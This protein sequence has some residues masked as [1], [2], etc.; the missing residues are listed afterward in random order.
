MPHLRRYTL[1]E[2]I[3]RSDHT[4][5]Y[6]GYRND[7]RAKVLAKCLA[8]E[9]AGPRERA[10]LRHE[11]AILKG[12]EVEGIVRAL[13]LTEQDHVLA[14]VV[15][16]PGGRPLRA[17]I[18][19]ELMPLADA[20]RVAAQIARALEGL[21]LRHVIHK[22]VRPE[23]IFDDPEAGRACLGGFG[24]ATRLQQEMP[25][26]ASPDALEGTLAY[27]SP[28]QTGRMNRA[29]DQ[30]TDLYS[31]GA[32]L[33][34]MLTGAPPFAADDSLELV[35]SH[36]AKAP[37][38]PHEISPSVPR[39][40]SDVVIKLLSKNAEDRYQRAAGVAAD[41]ELC[42]EAIAAGRTIAPFALDRYSHGGS[43]RM[44]QRLYG[45]DDELA[46]LLSAWQRASRGKAELVLVTGYSGIGKSV[47]V[48]EIH[49]E[50]AKTG[51]YFIAGKF[52]QL[53]RAVPYAS[54][55]EA[56][57]E[58]VHQLL[59]ERDA[60]LDRWRSRI[61]AA[62]GA[63]GKVLTDLI[64]DLALIIGPQPEL[65]EL[66]APAAQNR[67]ALVFQDFVRVFAS[68][69]H[70]LVI[71][72][73]DLQWADPASLALL[74]LLVAAPE[75]GSLL[76]IGAYRSNEVDAA[77]PLSRAVGEIAEAARVSEI[78]LPPLER[79]DVTR[80][81]ADALGAEPDGVESLAGVVYEKT[82]G[83]PFFLIQFLAALR[84]DDLLAFDPGAGTFRW[85]AAAIRAR[86]ITDNVVDFMVERIRRLAPGTQRALKLAACIGHRFDLR[87]LAMIREAPPAEVAAELWEA[88]DA[89]VLVPLGAEYRFFHGDLAPFPPELDVA[90][91]F[92]HDR[93]QQAAYSL[94]GDEGDAALH[95]RIGRIMLTGADGAPGEALF[96]IVS[97]LNLGAALIVDA[98][99]KRRL[100]R[101]DLEA[102]RKAK[103]ATA[104]Q[105]AASHLAVGTSL[106][107]EASWGPDYELAFALYLERAE[108][109][110]LAGALAEAE[111]LQGALL[112]RARTNLDRARVH[113]LRV[114]LYNAQGRDGDAIASGLEGL[115]LLG[116]EVFETEDEW[117]TA[118]EAELREVEGALASGVGAL[119]D[120]PPLV[121]P[122]KR[123]AL[124][125][126]TDL[127]APA[128]GLRP[129]F[130]N[131]VTVK[132][133][134]LSRRYGNSDVSAQGY[135]L[136]GATLVNFLGRYAEA[137]EFERLAIA[138][139]ERSGNAHRGCMLNF[140]YATVSH[141]AVHWRSLLP[142][143]D[144]AY[145]AGLESG[146]LIYLSYACSHK[147]IARLALGDPLPVVA[148]EADRFLALMRRTRVASS[149]AILAAA[150]QLMR[151]LEGRTAARDSLNDDQ[152]DEAEFVASLETARLTVPLSWY[153]LIKGQLA[154][155]AEDYAGAAALL[156]R[157]A[158]L[159]SYNFTPDVR[160]YACLAILAL[161]PEDE[162]TE[163]LRPTLTK[164]AGELA[165]WAAACADNYLH[166][167]L[168]VEAEFARVRGESD[169]AID[170]Y[171]RAIAAAQAG[172]WVR[173]V[174][175]GN[176][177]CAKFH[178]RRGRAKI[179]HAYLSDAYQAYGQWGVSAK[180]HDLAVRH[181]GTVS[182]QGADA[183]A[184][185]PAGGRPLAD[186]LDAVAFVRVLQTLANE[187]VLHNVLT[188]LMQIV[189]Q[190]AGAQRGVL[191]LDR[192]GELS[193]EATATT[194]PD[195]VKV[196]PSTPLGEGADLAVSV[197]RYVERLKDPVIIDDA[198]RPSRFSADPYVA[199]RRPRSIACLAMVHQG[200]ARGVL[201]LENNATT[202]AFT[203]ERVDLLGLLLSQAAISVENALPNARAHEIAG[204]LQQLNEA[205]ERQV[206]ARTEEI[207]RVSAELRA[208]NAELSVELAERQR[209][210]AQR[211]ALQEEVVKMQAEKLAELSTPVIPI[212]EEILVMPLIGTMDAERAHSLLEAALSGA[213]ARR[214]RIMI[215]DITG[216]KLVDASVAGTLTR[217][218]SALRMLGTDVVLTGVSARVAQTLVGLDVKLGPLVTKSTLELG[219]AYALT[220]V[221]QRWVRAEKAGPSPPPRPSAE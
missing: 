56:F 65:P 85:D 70:P 201:Y 118:Y 23:D 15:A 157:A 197:V 188:R 176:E 217:T 21:H 140:F 129:N 73:D 66:P 165:I 28:E 119:V 172:G 76:V 64:P 95:L 49:K 208:A 190:N 189:I 3:Q 202:D 98:E 6:R 34:E 145:F 79:R 158:G 177:L 174:A 45:R 204:Q 146:D 159:Q 92:S 60:S 25:Q 39:A 83:N 32:T 215:L 17:R 187:F 77:H 127:A 128:F 186:Q 121:D 135:A 219:I 13:D 62:V 162:A 75:S 107:D 206:A 110:A 213:Q 99:E 117:Q 71:F 91:R 180:A 195:E 155:L 2:E 156:A 164:C 192:D 29:L 214:A 185:R 209:A 47:L 106:L 168:L 144:R 133:V 42:A 143:L 103:A 35:H 26:V 72:L 93:V 132:P 54:V 108:C 51:G 87:T 199:S 57:R 166:K 88:L 184:P 61:A 68:P 74:K 105:A 67:F 84:R 131:W 200:R 9:G 14:L 81:V 36:L 151:A 142:Y 4:V 126:L 167:H 211:A 136:F 196:G 221:G 170:L 216:M 153:C 12:L 30:R 183:P 109:E 154:Y 178:E 102:G 94:E 147:I 130:S 123:A 20:L 24:I 194:D 181:L 38:P 179:A 48:H 115:R 182:V 8:H 100:A 80:F 27:L 46:T 101:L 141:Y 161:G 86:M 218:A 138:L 31:L 53:S 149:K 19:A 193:V 50:I 198:S 11:Y 40:V 139:H 124:K 173:D 43:L 125:L 112:G 191:L 134:N 111:A 97:H 89:G 22:N 59:T 148:E 44:P 122:E 104:Y 7:D 220:R 55:T 78:A 69:E 175:L 5:L 114:I 82:R 205:L 96:E 116:V 16:D 63:K 1:V 163:R 10:K 37:A 52:D 150:R 203:R 18:R 212:T 152:F 41:L 120:A 171:E 207:E 160:Y 90:Y 113:T 137:H 210:E 169:R 58:L 33:Y